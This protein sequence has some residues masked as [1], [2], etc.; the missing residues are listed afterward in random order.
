[1]SP[2]RQWR[3][4]QNQGL[5]SLLVWVG[6]TAPKIMR[7]CIY[8]CQLFTKPSS[9]FFN[10][11]HF[12]YLSLSLEKF[13]LAALPVGQ[14]FSYRLLTLDRCVCKMAEVTIILLEFTFLFFL[15]FYLY[16]KLSFLLTAFCLPD[17]F[18]L[19][20]LQKSSPTKFQTTQSE[21]SYQALQ[22]RWNP[23]LFLWHRWLKYLYQLPIKSITPQRSIWTLSCTSYSL[24]AYTPIF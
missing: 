11:S 16:L 3:T 17:P 7:F 15:H 23:L 4:Q 13:N 24:R 19:L 18:F 9:S 8:L 20:V 21:F 22:D 14:K 10:Y 5:N 6:A 1:M 12:H 2:L